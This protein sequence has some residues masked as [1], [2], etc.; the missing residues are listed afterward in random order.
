MPTETVFPD[1]PALRK[2]RLADPD[3]LR[4]TPAYDGRL[5]AL[6]RNATFVSR[7]QL[8]A[9]AQRNRVV[10]G[11]S[12]FRWRMQRF[13]D[14]GLVQKLPRIHPH[15][16]PVYTITRAG[17]H[18]L[19]SFGQG[20]A[21]ITSASE[22]LADAIQA[23]HFLELN[24]VQLALYGATDC[25]LD[26]WYSDREIA[27][28]NYT[29]PIPFVKDYDAIVRLIVADNH[30]L[31][32]GV[33]YERNFKSEERYHE[34]ASQIKNERQLHLVLYL[35]ATGDMV[36]R[37]APALVCDPF[38]ICFASTGAFRQQLFSTNVAY[39]NGGKTIISSFQDFLKARKLS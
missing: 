29:Q 16:G 20:V 24:E 37:L 31:K 38:P 30:V 33:E 12:T 36:F 22:H 35:T 7:G 26:A 15:P 32:I 21:S 4:W 34:I 9:L 28:M 2:S 39:L 14:V 27:S 25:A 17:L 10:S 5:L 11:E 1:K 8:L 13:I 6:I 19:E 23:P 3:R 18:V